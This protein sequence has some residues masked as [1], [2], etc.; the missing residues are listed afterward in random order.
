[1]TKLKQRREELNLTQR[2]VANTVGIPYQVYQR[3]ENKTV[4]PNAKVACKIAKALKTTVE[5][6]Y[7]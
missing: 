5:E 3:Y 2:E 4:I 6:F 1:M 7:G